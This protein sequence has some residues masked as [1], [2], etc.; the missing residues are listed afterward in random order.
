[1]PCADCSGESRNQNPLDQCGRSF[2]QCNNPCGAG[3][4]NT[5]ACESLPSQI[6]NFTL[7]FFGTVVKTEVNGQVV[8]SLPCALDVG[9]PNNPR[10]VDEGLAC[11]FLRLFRDGIGG[12][13][14][15]KGDTGAP[16][17]N[18]NNT[19]TVTLQAFAH[20]SINNPMTQIVV[21]QN[22]S[23]LEGIGLFIE[24]SGAYLVTNVAPGGVIFVTLVTP[25]GSPSAVIPVGSVVVPIGPP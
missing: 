14:G 1:M 5:P 24:H 15:P 23:I 3:P 13:T 11:Y 17:T 16:G 22:P 10:G 12:L 20:P 25:I 19:Y 6:Q 2:M 18:G 9:L 21:V 7:Q 8:W 4:G